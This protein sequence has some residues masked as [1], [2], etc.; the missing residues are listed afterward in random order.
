MLVE[1]GLEQLQANA[2]SQVLGTDAESKLLEIGKYKESEA[3][4]EE[5]P[6]PKVAVLL[7]VRIARV[8][9][10]EHNL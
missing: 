2:S 8:H 1:D 7:E 6:H 5:H 10:R 4:G 3:H 9:H